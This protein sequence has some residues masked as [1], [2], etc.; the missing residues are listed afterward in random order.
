LFD[1]QWLLGAFFRFGWQDDNAI[2]DIDTI[3]SSGINKNGK[4]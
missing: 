1:T 3:Y 4:L 2:V